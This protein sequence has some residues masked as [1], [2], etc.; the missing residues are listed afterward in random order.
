MVFF[1]V[2]IFCITSK[3]G[4]KWMR[5]PG[6]SRLVRHRNA[7]ITRHPNSGGSAINIEY[8]QTQVITINARLTV[9]YRA[10]FNGFVIALNRSKKLDIHF[11]LP[12]EH[13]IY[14]F[15]LWFSFMSEYFVLHQNEVRNGCEDL[16]LVGWLD[17]EMLI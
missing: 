10:Y 9:L 16:V 3:R 15:V 17:I 4:K 6:S 14:L 7:P 5:G 12:L 2:R 11:I 8:N 13:F 1:Y